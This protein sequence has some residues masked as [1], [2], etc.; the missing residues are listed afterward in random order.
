M[1]MFTGAGAKKSSPKAMLLDLDDRFL[2]FYPPTSY[3]HYNLS[4]NY[5]FEEEEGPKYLK[6]FLKKCTKLLIVCDP[7]FGALARVI[8]NNIATLKAQVQEMAP[9]AEILT[10]WI[11]PYF[12]TKHMAEVAPDLKMCHFIVEYDNHPVF[13]K[14]NSTRS[15]VR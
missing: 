12:L 14:G 7:P 11:F 6:L 13:K 15:P 9:E 5:F 8:A 10:Y 2:Q 4:S 1:K 3:Q